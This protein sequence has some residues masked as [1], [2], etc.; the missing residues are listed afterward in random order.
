MK[1]NY[2]LTIVLFVLCHCYVVF[3]QD[4][5]QQLVS[6]D[7]IPV[8]AT[9]RKSYCS[10]K[11]KSSVLDKQSKNIIDELAVFFNEQ[12]SAQKRFV[13]AFQIEGSSQEIQNNPLI[14]SERLSEILRY[15]SLQTK[16]AM[17]D[18]VIQY[19]PFFGFETEGTVTNIYFSLRPKK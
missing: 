7:S 13:L 8:I 4:C 11:Y 5:K 10:F 9:D 14:N 12:D 6:Q 2:N 16:G 18:I 15:L 1:I 3:A 17:I 19:I